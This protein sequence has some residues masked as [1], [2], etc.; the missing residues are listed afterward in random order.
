MRIL[1][2]SPV[3]FTEALKEC[4]KTFREGGFKAVIKRYGW[5]IFALFFAYYLIRDSILYLLIPYLV[6]KHF[7][8]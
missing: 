7:I 2:I 1:I 5:K 3:N 4:K 8:N 6:A